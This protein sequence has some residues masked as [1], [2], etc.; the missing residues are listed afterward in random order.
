MKIIF[1][2]FAVVLTFTSCQGKEK[3]IEDNIAE[4]RE[5]LYEGK[6]E[7]VDVSLICGERESEYVL[8]GFA[9]DLIEFGVLTFDVEDIE[10]LSLDSM[11]Y[12][13]TVGTTRYDGDLQKNPFVGTLVADVKKNINV[14]S[15]VSAKIMLGDFV[16]EIKLTRI[17]SDWE[18]K[19]SDVK[20]ILYKNFKDEIN[21]LVEDGVF[22]GEVYIK[23]LND[24][25]MYIGDY[26][27][28]VSIISRSGGKLN[29]IISKKTGE[30][31]SQ[32]STL[33]KI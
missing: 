27:W 4:I 8:N 11:K 12:V 18:I 2:L 7:G 21:S 25:D 29:A 19:S 16:K 5:C 3:Y 9:T 26:Y 28:Y 20:K 23:I 14:T 15:G 1:L 6:F 32:N 31:L 33:D 13:L 10:N 30:I 24:A 22:K 17:D